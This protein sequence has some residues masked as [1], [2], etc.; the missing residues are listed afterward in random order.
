MKII[1]SPFRQLI[2]APNKFLLDPINA[3]QVATATMTNEQLPKAGCNV[4]GIVVTRCLDED[5]RIENIG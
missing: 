4:E 2:L 1:I 5:I 3:Q